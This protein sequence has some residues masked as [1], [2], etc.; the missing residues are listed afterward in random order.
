L[1]QYRNHHYQSYPE[2]NMRLQDAEE[3]ARRLRRATDAMRGSR[4][5]RVA[6]AIRAAAAGLR[7]TGTGR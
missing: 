1:G 4:S 2:L 3:W 7:R 5:W 6:R